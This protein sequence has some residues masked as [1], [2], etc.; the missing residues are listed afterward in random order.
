MALMKPEENEQEM[1]WLNW[2]TE[3]V[4]VLLAL[5]PTL[6]N[7][8][9]RA[10]ID[11][12]LP[13]LLEQISQGRKM[14]FARLVGL[15]DKMVGSWFYLRQLPS[16]ENL[17][18]VCFAVNLSLQELLMQEQITCSL[19]PE[20]TQELWSGHHR[21]TV[22][23][24]WKSDQIRKTL[25]AIAVNEEVSPPSLNAVARQLGCDAHSLKVYH[26]VP[27]QMIS[28]RYTAY[29]QTKAQTTI[30]QHCREVQD[31]VNHLIEQGI[32]PTTRNVALI[33]SKQGIFRSSVLRDRKSVV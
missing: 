31:A 16:V 18:R 10:R 11:E 22:R 30:E 28:A 4:G 12:G 9:S 2:C 3:Q 26:P 1:I 5:V 15:S 8:P 19:R 17:L 14:T 24:F 29:M 27:S 25:E 20:R 33:L 21:Q 23:G 6:T 7:I 13:A 32:P